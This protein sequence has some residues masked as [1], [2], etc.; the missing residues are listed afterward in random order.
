M[1]LRGKYPSPFSPE[2]S[3]VL[4]GNWHVL[5]ALLGQGRMKA[6]WI[7]YGPRPKCSEPADVLSI[8]IP[9]GN[10]G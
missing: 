2:E 7:Y 1:H 10:Y 5:I 3:I 6:F 9:S 8:V 4:S